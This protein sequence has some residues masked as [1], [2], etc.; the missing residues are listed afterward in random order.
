MNL[1]EIVEQLESCNF[2]CEGG[3]L[4]NNSAFIELKR[5]EYIDTHIDNSNDNERSPC[6]DCPCM[7]E[8]FPGCE[9]NCGNTRQPR[10]HR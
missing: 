6:F 7:K 5:L 10:Y 1:K 9:Q 8:Y 4:Q 2:E 3:S